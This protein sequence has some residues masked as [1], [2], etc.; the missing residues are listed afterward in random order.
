MGVSR[1]V[2]EPDGDELSALNSIVCRGK[3]TDIRR[4]GLEGCPYLKVSLIER[5]C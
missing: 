1:E 5:M 3:N 4:S 2:L